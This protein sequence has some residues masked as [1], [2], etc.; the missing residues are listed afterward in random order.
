M[1][2]MYT[3]DIKGN[4]DAEYVPFAMFDTEEEA[5]EAREAYIASQWAPDVSRVYAVEA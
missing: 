1:T 5:Q 2:K 4:A 3:F